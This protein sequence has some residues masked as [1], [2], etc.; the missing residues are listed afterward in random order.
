MH[1]EMH[2]VWQNQKQKKTF[3]LKE[4]ASVVDET[5]YPS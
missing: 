3:Q 4:L 5:Y 1:S 2:P